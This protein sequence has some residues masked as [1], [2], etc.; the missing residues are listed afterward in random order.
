[1]CHKILDDF[2]CLI[3]TSTHC[4]CVCVCVCV[5]CLFIDCK[6]IKVT[7]P[8]LMENNFWVTIN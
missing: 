8:F 4:V 6:S 3:Y 1:M 2:E 5:F 7:L